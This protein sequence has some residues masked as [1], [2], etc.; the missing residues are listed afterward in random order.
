MGWGSFFKHLTNPVGSLAEDIFGSKNK[1]TIA[2]LNP[3]TVETGLSNLADRADKGD[4]WKPA[5]IDAFI[6]PA[7]IV[8]KGAQ[9]LGKWDFAKDVVTNPTADAIITAL[10]SIYNPGVG[11][12]Y[13]KFRGEMLD[14]DDKQSLKEAA[15]V[16]GSGEL[17]KALGGAAAAPT[18]SEAATAASVG[19][20][21]GSYASQQAAAPILADMA[22]NAA[23]NQQVLQSLS[24]TAAQAAKEET[25]PQ[26]TNTQGGIGDTVTRTIEHNAIMSPLKTVAEAIYP[27]PMPENEGWA[28]TYQPQP[29]YSASLDPEA[30]TMP[31]R[32]PTSLMRK[33]SGM[34]TETPGALRAF[35]RMRV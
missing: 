30:G 19:A 5:S 21:E 35:N 17:G 25:V 18:T 3:N 10:L 2:L 9:E 13:R 31:D 23:Y 34:A 32:M 7:D 33:L 20:G 27:T 15:L 6:D 24:G 16:Y 26:A 1:S 4:L 22:E 14:Q 12:G 29:Q 8:S 11:A 28:N